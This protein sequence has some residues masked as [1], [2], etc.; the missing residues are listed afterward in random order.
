MEDMILI[1]NNYTYYNKMLP[2]CYLII[3]TVSILYVSIK[4]NGQLI[5]NL[6]HNLNALIQ[7]RNYIKYD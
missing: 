2:K 1:I 6:F 5:C 7:L 3:F 4:I